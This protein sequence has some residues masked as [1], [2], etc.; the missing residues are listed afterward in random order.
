MDAKIRD[1]FRE[2]GDMMLCSNRKVAFKEF[3]YDNENM[4]IEYAVC[5][6]IRGDDG[7][8]HFAY[9]KYECNVTMEKRLTGNWFMKMIGRGREE[10]ITLE[11][12]NLIMGT[13]VPHQLLTEMKNEGII[14]AIT[15]V[16][17]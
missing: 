16:D 10:P 14:N 12:R 9:G 4:R 6:G 13:F 17:A 3:E 7:V 8:F 5:I 11:Q 2:M 1:T 15:Y